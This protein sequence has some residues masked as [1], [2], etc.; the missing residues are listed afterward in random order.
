MPFREVIY[1]LKTQQLKTNI[2][3]KN[4]KLPFNKNNNWIERRIFNHINQSYSICITT[5]DRGI[6]FG[7]Y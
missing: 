6:Y 1:N 3:Q 2:W 5:A 4:P 7:Y